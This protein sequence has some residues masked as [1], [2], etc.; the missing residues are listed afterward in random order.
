VLVVEDEQLIRE[1]VEIL[2]SIE[3]CDVRTAVNGS[4]ALEKLDGWMPDLI[5]LDLTLPGMSGR[6]FIQ[7]YQKTPGPHGPVILL[8]GQTLDPGEVQAMGAAG[9]LPK[10]FDVNDLLDVVANFTEC[11]EEA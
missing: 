5:L 3:G 7:A 8:T 1:T 9:M 2:I 6:E 4:D 11:I 10:P